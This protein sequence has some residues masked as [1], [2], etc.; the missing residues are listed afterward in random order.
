LFLTSLAQSSRPHKL[1]KRRRS[2]QRNDSISRAAKLIGS[3]LVHHHIDPINQHTKAGFNRRV[4]VRGD[5]SPVG[6]RAGGEQVNTTSF[7]GRELRFVVAWLASP[8]L[9]SRDAGGGHCLTCWLTAV[10]LSTE[11]TWQRSFARG[12]VHCFACPP[13]SG[14]SIRSPPRLVEPA[15]EPFGVDHCDTSLWRFPPCV[16]LSS[17]PGR[18][19][20]WA[21]AVGHNATVASS[22]FADWCAMLVET[23]RRPCPL[24]DSPVSGVGQHEDSFPFVARPHARRA[25]KERFFDRVTHSR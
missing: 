12:V 21:F 8:L 2:A 18:R 14:S 13:S 6:V 19:L 9:W 24:A 7:S 22:E 5:V 20:S 17:T 11:F 23:P 10:L 3:A 25:R 1:D 4:E 15:A 16:L